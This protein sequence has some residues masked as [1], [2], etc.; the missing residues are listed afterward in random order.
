[1][2][3]R[4]IGLYHL[5]LP[6]NFIFKTA[7]TSLNHRETLVIRA[8]DELGHTG[9]GEAVA[10]NE[11]FYTRE[12]LP[13]SKAVL[14]NDYIPGLI[15]REISHPFDIHAGMDLSYPMAEAGL[16]N[17]LLDLYARRMHRPIMDVVFEERRNTRI[18]AGMALGDLDNE[19]LIRQIAE[20]RREGYTRFKL[21]IKPANGLAKLKAIRAVYPDLNLLADA[22]MSYRPEQM[23]GLKALDQ[24]NLLCIEEP[25]PAGSFAAY[26]TLQAEMKTPL[27]LDE[28]IQTPADLKT[29]IAMRALGAVN[30]K[31]GRVGGM[32]YVRQMIELCR[33]HQIK[34]WIGSMVESGISR[35]LHVQLASLK[36]TYIPGDLSPSRRYFPR[37][38]IRPEI[39]VEDGMI[40]VPGGWGLGVEI[41]EKALRDFTLDEVWQGGV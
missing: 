35:I 15:G 31:V 16:E 20:Y 13:G 6:L 27:C 19:T 3:I 11:P 9:Y 14:L 39:T 26:R 25:L 33:Q 17:A 22:N 10:F 38:V 40:D 8:E 5:R 36:D 7:Q 32:Y 1:M 24:F 41:D 29:A 34:Y 37:D 23:A 2:K 4:R 30:I 28:S 21:K 12:T 18:A